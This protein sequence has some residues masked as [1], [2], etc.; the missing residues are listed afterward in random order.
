MLYNQQ[1][2][3]LLGLDPS[4]PNHSTPQHTAYKQQH[5]IVSEKESIDNYCTYLY[6]CSC[7]RLKLMRLCIPT[8]GGPP[9]TLAL[10]LSTLFLCLHNTVSTFNAVLLLC[11]EQL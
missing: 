9:S 6:D 11:S 5:I 10:A 2:D 4:H 7:R 8:A 3:D 1:S